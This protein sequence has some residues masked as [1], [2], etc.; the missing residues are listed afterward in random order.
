MKIWPFDAYAEAS[1]GTHISHADLKKALQPFEKIRKAVGDKMDIHVEFHSLWDPADRDRDRQ[2]A[3]AVRPV[4]VR[5]SDQ[6]DE[7]RRARR[8]R[9]PHERA[10]HRERDARHA[11]GVPRAAREARR[12]RGACS[13]SPGAAACRRR[14]RSP[15]W[16][17]PTSCRSRRTTAPARSCSTA[18]VHLSLNC[19]N[20]LVQEMVRAF[21]F[22][23]YGELVTQL[24]PV[25]K[26]YISATRARPGHRAA[27]R[28][29]EAQ[30]RAD[31][32]QQALT[33]I[34]APTRI[35]TGR[36]TFLPWDHRAPRDGLRLIQRREPR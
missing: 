33:A 14:R 4:L 18:S 7:P 19:P 1:N 34:P 2:G 24:P 31:P 16:P 8:L 20:T 32:R 17:R 30:G 6:D 9:A 3:R 23:W 13:T 5:G 28:R 12:Q 21:Y 15:P 25:E 27:T 36:C 26:G 11:L 22:D 29:A 35:D 10:G